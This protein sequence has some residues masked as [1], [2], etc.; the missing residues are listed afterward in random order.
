ML[1]GRKTSNFLCPKDLDEI[2]LEGAWGDQVFRYA[3]VSIEGCREEEFECLPVEDL[4]GVYFN[5]V[6]LQAFP[7]IESKGTED[8]II[9]S[10]DTR[11][12]F[13]L[14]SNLS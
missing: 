8:E 2:I 6:M 9:Y 3:K 14:N 12:F 5:F 1:S 7:N 13:I 10:T 4:N 11:H